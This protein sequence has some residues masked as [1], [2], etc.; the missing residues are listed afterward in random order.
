VSTP[1]LLP[2]A[3]S[4]DLARRKSRDQAH[5]EWYPEPSSLPSSVCAPTLCD[6]PEPRQCLRRLAHAL[7]RLRNPA[8]ACMLGGFTSLLPIR[9]F[10]VRHISKRR[11][12]PSI[13][14]RP[15]CPKSTH[16]HPN[17]RLAGNLKDD[18][19]PMLLTAGERRGPW[20]TA[21]RCR[22]VDRLIQCP[23]LSFLYH[24]HAVR[25]I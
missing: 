3:G 11:F 23:T 20:H 7:C 18:L 16:L 19:I 15:Q 4:R 8:A 17:Q 14:G 2:A 24:L 10:C 25:Q 13:E 12:T 21:K 9:C 1:A 5:R 22:W 6:L